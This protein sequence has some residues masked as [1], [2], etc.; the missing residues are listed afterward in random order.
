MPSILLYSGLVIVL[1]GLVSVI[2]PLRFLGVTSR[3]MALLA[4]ACGVVL[5]VCGD[6]VPGRVSQM[7]TPTAVL[8]QAFP[9]FQARESHSCRIHS[10]PERIFQAIRAVTP[11]DIR[12]FRSLLWI[13]YPRSAARKHA[14]LDKSMDVLL[15][16]AGFITLAED[17][18]RELVLGAVGRFWGPRGS[19]AERVLQVK[20]SPR[21]GV[22]ARITTPA[23][24]TTFATPGYTKTAINFRV[25]DEGHGWCR[26]S[27][28]TRVLGTD[29]QARQDFQRYWYVIAPG[30]AIIRSQ[31]LAAIKKR[32]EAPA[33]TSRRPVVP[34]PGA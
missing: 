7:V 13:R 26:L 6:S 22:S 19:Q 18:H 21:L 4:I 16:R 25:E 28:E 30:S 34:P 31:W 1:I 29:S 33:D 32:A 11:L 23:E 15:H 2:V 20:G 5:V 10:S 8:D 24:F 3:R 27:T 9:T 17:D 12:F 14:M